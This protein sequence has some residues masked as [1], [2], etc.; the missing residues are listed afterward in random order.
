MSALPPPPR[1]R[2]GPRW[3]GQPGGS[4]Y[5]TGPLP[6]HGLAS[7]GI[8]DAAVHAFSAALQEVVA[9]GVEAALPSHLPAAT[10]GKAK[11]LS[12]LHLQFACR[13]AGYV[14]LSPIWEKV[15]RVKGRT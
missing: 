10:P 4:W 13:M 8:S 15:A 11:A 6:Y 14:Y 1:A 2:R 9:T 12:L 3:M 5:P 7:L